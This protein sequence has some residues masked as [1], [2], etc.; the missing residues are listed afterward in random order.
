MDA[1]I[2]VN[3]VVGIGWPEGGVEVTAT[4]NEI[5]ATMNI[6]THKTARRMGRR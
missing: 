3:R 4:R 2:G 1:R 6:E 5:M